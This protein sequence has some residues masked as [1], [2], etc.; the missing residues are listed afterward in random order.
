MKSSM[1]LVFAV[2][3]CLQVV[4]TTS[5]VANLSGQSANV[6]LVAAEDPG[7]VVASET[8]NNTST[9]PYNW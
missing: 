1:A 4:T 7:S 2:V 6:I 8:K 5:A 3:A 9:Y